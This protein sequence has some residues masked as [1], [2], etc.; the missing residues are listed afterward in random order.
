MIDGSSFDDFF[1]DLH[2]D[3]G[4][5]LFTITVLDPEAGLA[6]RVYTSDAEAYPASGTKPMSQGAWTDKVIGRGETFVANTVAEFAVFF[7]DHALI[8]SLGCQSALNIPVS[9]GDQVIGTVNVLDQEHHFTPDRVVH[10]QAIIAERHDEL[11]AALRSF[12]PE[13]RQ[14]R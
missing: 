11:V 4:G 1:A 5:R 7:G 12:A 8:E 6:T 3:V 9:H 13:A 14:V 2:R 10:C